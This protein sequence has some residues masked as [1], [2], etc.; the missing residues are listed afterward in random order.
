MTWI[1]FVCSWI[2][3]LGSILAVSSCSFV[4]VVV[5]QVDDHEDIISLLKPVGPLRSYDATNHTCPIL[6]SSWNISNP[7]HD[8][9]FYIVLCAIAILS[10][11]GVVFGATAVFSLPTATSTI[12][13]QHPSN[14]VVAPILSWI[15]KRSTSSS[16]ANTNNNNNNNNPR[17]IYLLF[18]GSCTCQILTL[19][20]FFSKVFQNST[21]T[22]TTGSTTITLGWGAIFSILSTV[23]YVTSIISFAIVSK[24]SMTNNQNN[25]HYAFFDVDYMEAF[26]SSA[27]TNNNHSLTMPLIV[28]NTTTYDAQSNYGNLPPWVH[29]I[30]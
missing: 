15:C 9:F 14:T 20:M 22:T 5:Q 7:S 23:L 26:P 3:L 29:T 10:I 11:M 12:I 30:Q 21:T 18:L 17:R 2:G 19:G 16:F 25:H 27:S 8:V 6:L 13:P 28:D 1:C 24:P 4:V